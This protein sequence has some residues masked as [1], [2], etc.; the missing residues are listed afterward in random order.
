MGIKA[1]IETVFNVLQA[2]DIKGTPNN[3]DA[4]NCAY[5]ILREIYSELEAGENAGKD[6]AEA[7]PSG[8]DTD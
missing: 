3:V 4:L 1:R 5:S 2:I 6:G 7:N 8:R